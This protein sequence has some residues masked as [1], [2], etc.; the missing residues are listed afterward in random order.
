MKKLLLC[1]ITLAACLGASAVQ[2]QQ[3]ADPIKRT[4]VQRAEFPGDKMAT[5]LVMIEIV[6]NGVVARHTHPGVEVGYVLDGSV[7][8]SIEGQPPK[9]FRQ[10]DTY[11]VPVTAPHVAKAGAGG[12]KLIGTFVVEKDK[13]LASPAP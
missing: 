6:P 12:V 11:M 9:L 1:T 3:P 5:L 7:E 4:I 8:F 13:P 10:G 2:A